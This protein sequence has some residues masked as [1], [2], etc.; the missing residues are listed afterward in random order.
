ME[1]WP[2][3]SCS[4][5]GAC[6]QRSPNR[7]SSGP[8]T[9]SSAV[10]QPLLQR[11]PQPLL[12]RSRVRA[13]D[14]LFRS[15]FAQACR[16][17]GGFGETVPGEFNPF[18]PPAF[19]AV[20]MAEQDHEDLAEGPQHPEEDEEHTEREGR[21]FYYKTCPCSDDCSNQSWKKADVWGWTA[22]D[23]KAKLAK[24]LTSSSLHNLSEE[25]AWQVVEEAELILG[26]MEKY[27]K[28]QH[29]K[30]EWKHAQAKDGGRGQ[31]RP[32]QPSFPPPGQELPLAVRAS[33]MRPFSE[34]QD[35]VVISKTKL[36]IVID[37]LSRAASSAKTSQKLAA[38]A[39]DAFGAE[40]NILSET[41][42]SFEA[43]KS[44]L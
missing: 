21:F 16:G 37:S 1:V 11:P 40:L 7:F 4:S 30:E 43:L 6:V 8:P 19:E 34:M 39:A 28:K 26:E 44:L 2:L 24:H 10:P 29:N 33:A 41:K 32:I 13:R 14:I 17:R 22:D 36:Q 31:K 5:H 9:A 25:E 27:K 3:H 20:A 42:A 35:G 18:I 12:P 38:T 15:Y 23:A